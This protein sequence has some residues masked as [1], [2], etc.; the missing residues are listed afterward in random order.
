MWFKIVQNK[1]GSIAT[2]A[3]VSGS[4]EDGKSVHYIEADSAEAACGILLARYAHVRSAEL[5]R[6]KYRVAQGICVCGKAIE[7]NRLGLSLCCECNDKITAQ[8]RT[9]RAAINAGTHVVRPMART[10]AEKAALALAARASEQQRSKTRASYK[11][12]IRRVVLQNCLEAFDHMTP[13]NFRAWLVEAL[14]IA[15]EKEIASAKRATKA[16]VT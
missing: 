10:A 12:R 9:R 5:A 8:A 15:Q 7:A 3:E 6:R 16:A 11:L 14:H 4:R 1:D 2:C 13:R